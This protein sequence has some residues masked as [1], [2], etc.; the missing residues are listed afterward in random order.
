MPSKMPKPGVMTS[1]NYV[2]T[3]Q[4]ALEEWRRSPA[5]EL[6][7]AEV[8]MWSKILVSKMYV[9]GNFESVKLINSQILAFQKLQF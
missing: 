3:I 7:A 6:E 8:P 1:K 9:F 5:V 4:L 2:K